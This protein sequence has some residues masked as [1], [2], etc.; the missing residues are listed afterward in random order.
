M[1]NVYMVMIVCMLGK[2]YK[3]SFS[4][5]VYKTKDMFECVHSELWDLASNPHI[6]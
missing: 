3:T 2:Y 5:G 4:T 6:G 1:K